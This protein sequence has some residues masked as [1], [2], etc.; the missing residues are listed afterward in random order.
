[1]PSASGEIAASVPRNRAANS[2]AVSGVS[3]VQVISAA[4]DSAA[5]S[6]YSAAN[7]G[8]DTTGGAAD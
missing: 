5:S 4:S 7:V 8:A 6:P 1:M 3:A 2:G